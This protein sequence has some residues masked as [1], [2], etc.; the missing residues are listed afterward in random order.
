MKIL[1]VEDE[2]HLNESIVQYMSKEGFICETVTTYSAA[3]QKINDYLYDVIV[4]D[5][6]L[7]DGNGLDL[8]RELKETSSDTGI[9]IISAKESLN[10]KLTGLDL[11]AD[12]Y[13]TKP[14]H[15]AELNSRIK[16]VIRRRKFRG[17]QSVTFKEVRIDVE[18]AQ[19]QINDQAVNLTKREY[20]SPVICC[21]SWFDLAFIQTEM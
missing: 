11:G 15:L 20:D 3:S 1:I 2:I 13:I 8:I 10:D 21:P 4:V 16:S 17:K 18:N 12:D 5:I 7:P 9:I 6:V 14:F 19:V